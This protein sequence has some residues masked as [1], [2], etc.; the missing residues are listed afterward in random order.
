[1]TNEQDATQR[2][3]VAES[4]ARQAVGLIEILCGRRIKA[5]ELLTAAERFPQP[6]ISLG[7]IKRV[8]RNHATPSP[9]P[10]LWGGFGDLTPVFR[11]L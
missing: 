10:R 8:F 1:M 9:R 11:N 3:E 4:H 2:I 6:C 5:T 7:R